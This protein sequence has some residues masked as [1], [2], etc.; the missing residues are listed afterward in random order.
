MMQ[1]SAAIKYGAEQLA[2]S[3]DSARLDSEMLLQKVL[4]CSKTFV[5]AHPDFLLT[6]EQLDCYQ[7]LLQRRKEHVPIAYMTGE[8]EFWAYNFKLSHTT[9]I[10]RPATE[11][12][13]E[14]I[15]QLD[16]PEDAKVCD[17][18]TGSG[19]IAISLGKAHPAWDIIATDIQT[20]A[21]AVAAHN[22]LLNAAYNIKFIWSNWFRRLSGY[23]FNL[24]V[25]NPPYIHPHDPHLLQADVSHEPRI[26]LESKDGSCD[27]RHIMQQAKNFLHADGILMLEHGYDQQSEVVAWLKFYGYKNILPGLDYAGVRRYCLAVCP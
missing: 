11:S 25:S 16:L 2:T 20:T 3:S 12:L 21:L 4:N 19:A 6:A 18:G 8:R 13:I 14:A 22:A 15:L 10:P 5:Y 27:L 7:Y 24:I 26:A 1:L 9:L 23:K 17:L